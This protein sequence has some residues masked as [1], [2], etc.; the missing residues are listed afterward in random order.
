MKQSNLAPHRKGDLATRRND[1][2]RLLERMIGQLVVGTTF[3]RRWRISRPSS[4]GRTNGH[5]GV[6]VERTV[7]GWASGRTRVEW[8]GGKG[9]VG[10][11]VLVD[12]V[13]GA[14]KVG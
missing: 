7:E 8:N 12:R 9:C 5:V 6:V 13:V 1:P 14:D 11:A 2:V 4:F 3:G 10:W